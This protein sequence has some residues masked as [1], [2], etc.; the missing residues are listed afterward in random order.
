[1]YDPWMAW[2]IIGVACIGLEMLMPGFVIFFFGLGGL[3]TA[4]S[5]FIPFVAEMLWLQ[6]LLFVVLSAL[7]LVFLRRKFT[8][9]FGGTIFDPDK[10]GSVE[11]DGIGS[12]VEVLEDVTEMKDGRIRFRGT[13]WKA[14][15]RGG[16]CEKGSIARLVAREDL[17]YIVERAVTK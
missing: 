17:T 2:A 14:R 16:E 1:M 9:V 12:T 6:I 7:S 11:D 13:S 3:A 8:K 15:T 4:I 10:A 5:C